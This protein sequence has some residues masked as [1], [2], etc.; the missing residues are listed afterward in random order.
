M[1]LPVAEDKLIPIYQLIPL[2]TR[3]ALP[4]KPTTYRIR[5]ARGSYEKG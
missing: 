5:V 2:L 3:M 4:V 1:I